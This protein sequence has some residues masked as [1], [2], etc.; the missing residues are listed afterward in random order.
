MRQEQG[1][2][3]DVMLGGMPAWKEKTRKTENK[4]AR[5][6]KN[7]KSQK[8][9][10]INMISDAREPTTWRNATAYGVGH[11]GMAQDDTVKNC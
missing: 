4:M 9:P 10:T 8:G 5:H 3:N 7:H 6:S 2:E 1:M 11:T